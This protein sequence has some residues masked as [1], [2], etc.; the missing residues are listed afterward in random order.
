VDVSRVKKGAL[1]VKRTKR[2]LK[3]RI[4]WQINTALPDVVL[5]AIELW[6]EAVPSGGV[7]N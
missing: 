4:G 3:A 2:K 5:K 6:A 1:M 7:G